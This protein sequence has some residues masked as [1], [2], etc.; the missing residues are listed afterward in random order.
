VSTRQAG[1]RLLCHAGLGVYG[2]AGGVVDAAA[3]PRPPFRSVL[4]IL[5]IR[6]PWTHPCRPH[7]RRGNLGEGVRERNENSPAFQGREGDRDDD[8]VW[9]GLALVDSSCRDGRLRC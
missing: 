8:C 2:A 9:V 5:I 6:V 1:P 3:S 7:D 4:V